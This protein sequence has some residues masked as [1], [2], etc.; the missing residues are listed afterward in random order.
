MWGTSWERNGR[1][2]ID[3]NRKLDSAAMGDVA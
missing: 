3:S 1:F 2:T